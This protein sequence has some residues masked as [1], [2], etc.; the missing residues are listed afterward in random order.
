MDLHRA[1]HLY[2]GL[3]LIL[4]GVFALL[5]H[6]HFWGI[7]FSGIGFWCAIDDLYQHWRQAYEPKYHS[8]LH[9]LYV[10]Y[11]YRFWIIRWLNTKVDEFLHTQRPV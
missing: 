6:R 10:T 5:L 11:L 9:R 8:F 7:L 2:L 1:H 3:F 4:L